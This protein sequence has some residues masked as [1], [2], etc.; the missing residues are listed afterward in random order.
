MSMSDTFEMSV[1]AF[2]AF[3]TPQM[4]VVAYVPTGTNLTT[5]KGDT[6]VIELV[7]G[8]DVETADTLARSLNELAVKVSIR[9]LGKSET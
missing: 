6:L 9:A 2:R 1:G 4:Q 3:V 8:T 5:Y 7:S